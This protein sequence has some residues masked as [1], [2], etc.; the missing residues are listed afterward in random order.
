MSRFLVNASL[1]ILTV[2]VTSGQLFSQERVKRERPLVSDVSVS[3]RA[4]TFET[5]PVAETIQLAVSGPFDW[6]HTQILKGGQSGELPLETRKGFRL[7]DGL[8]RVQLSAVAK[9]DQ[10]NRAQLRVARDKGDYAQVVKLNQKLAGAQQFHGTFR[11]VDG[12]FVDPSTREESDRDS[13]KD[14]GVAPTR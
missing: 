3:D 2:S 7:P 5:N 11:I 4:I 10:T 8:Y 12:K 1:V 14:Q 13:E 6:Q 9:S